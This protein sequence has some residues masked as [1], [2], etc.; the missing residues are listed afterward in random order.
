MGWVDWEMAQLKVGDKRLDKRVK[1]TIEK[2]AASN[3]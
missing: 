1:H 3:E 2:L